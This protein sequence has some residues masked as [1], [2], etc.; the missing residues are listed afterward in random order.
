ME[1]NF[2]KVIDDSKQAPIHMLMAKYGLKSFPKLYLEAHPE[3]EDSSSN[4]PDAII[5]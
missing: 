4:Q 2:I 5:D 1:E 3:I